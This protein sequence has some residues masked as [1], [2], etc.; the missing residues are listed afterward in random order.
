ML[1]NTSQHLPDGL[2]ID[3]RRLSASSNQRFFGEEKWIFHHE[4]LINFFTFRW[5]NRST[6]M[7]SPYSSH[8]DVNPTTK[9][10]LW[11][12]S[13]AR[14]MVRNI[15]FQFHDFFNNSFS[16]RHHTWSTIMTSRSATHH[17]NNFMAQSKRWYADDSGLLGEKHFIKFIHFLIISISFSDHLQSTDYQGNSTVNIKVNSEQLIVKWTVNS[18]QWSMLFQQ[19][20]R[21]SCWGM[22][23]E[24]R[25]AIAFNSQ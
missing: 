7:T 24:F 14:P 9:S 17:N 22:K 2:D 3:F 19:H 23:I 1:L 15:E 18:E 16:F 5:R 12:T 8:P 21:L 4:N 10:R 13:H 6:S 20:P 11:S 25:S